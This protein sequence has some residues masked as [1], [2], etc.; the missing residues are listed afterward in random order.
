MSEWISCDKQLPTKPGMVLVLAET[1]D[2]EKPFIHTAWYEPEG[3][4][5]MTGW[6]IFPEAF[7]NSIAYWMP[8]PKL[9]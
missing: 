4:G 6:Q 1:M 2:P 8:F 9:P 7:I 3:T 5:N